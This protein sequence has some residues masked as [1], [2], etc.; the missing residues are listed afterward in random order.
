MANRGNS[1]MTTDN[2]KTAILVALRRFIR[3]RPGLDFRIYGDVTAYRAEARAIAKDLREATALLRYVE[4]HDSISADDLIEAAK[5]SYSGRLSIVE[6]CA[7]CKETAGGTGSMAG[8][9]HAHGP[10]DHEY[11]PIIR[12]D[13][14]AGQYWP[15]EYRRA[16]CAVLA[17][18]IWEYWR[19]TCMPEPTIGPN[20]DQFYAGMSPGDFL[21]RT[22]MREFN[23]G[24]ARRWFQ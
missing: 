14:C 15:T 10:R 12:I 9:V 5:H 19:A 8:T 7:T 4:W 24:I 1:V 21:R 16:T 17:S 6:R 22:A 13:Y 3:Q 23:R 20:G 18:A 2:R 11:R